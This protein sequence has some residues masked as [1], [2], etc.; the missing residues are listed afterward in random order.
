MKTL[1]PMLLKCYPYLNHV[2]ES[3][4]NGVIDQ[5]DE[6]TLVENPHFCNCS[7]NY[8]STIN[9]V[10]NDKS[11]CKLFLQLGIVFL[12][13]KP[14][15]LIRLKYKLRASLQ[16]KV[17]PCVNTISIATTN[18]FSRKMFYQSS[19]GMLS[20]TLAWW[21]IFIRWLGMMS[22]NI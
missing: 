19:W 13:C 17:L 2:G 4:S 18:H 10:E 12:N 20:T 14:T 3:E 9:I 16:L 8:C 11:S 5:K 6:D 22:T 15:K 21:M 1:Y 7:F